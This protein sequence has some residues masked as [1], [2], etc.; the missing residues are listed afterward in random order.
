MLESSEVMLKKRESNIELLRILA[1]LF[2]ICFHYAYKSGYVLET[3]NINSI[4][5]K[6]FWF[7]GELGVSLFVLI[8]GYFQIKDKFSLKKLIK[9]ILEVNFYYLLSIILEYIIENI[10]TIEHAKV[11][12]PQFYFST[13][14]PVIA[15]EYWF[16][17]SY[18]LIYIF[19]PFLNKFIKSMSKNEYK[20]LLILLIVIWSIIPTIFGFYRNSTESLLFYNRLI[21]M[22]I[23]Y[24]LGAYIRLYS[25]KILEKRKNAIIFSIVACSTLILGI[26]LIYKYQNFFTTEIAYFWTPNS[27]PI[28]MLSISIFSIF[29]KLRVKNNKIINLFAS[30]TFGIYMLHDGPLANILWKNI[31]KTLQCLNS[32]YYF[33]YII[34]HTFIIFIVGS[35]IDLI[36]QIIEKF[37]LN[38]ILNSKIIK[39][40]YYQVKTKC[41]KMFNVI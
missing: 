27:I 32:P 34:C 30:T 1:I 23:L 6:S 21:W 11:T 10:M 26:I 20:K 28:L 8:T 14:F 31:F 35:V 41:I 33:I 13:L 38:K 25:I 19:S 2:I 17:T 15:G 12:L 4:I 18:I 5:I 40:F 9:L 7:L 22:G 29:L 16:A 3:L 24:F 37:T 36:R 39:K